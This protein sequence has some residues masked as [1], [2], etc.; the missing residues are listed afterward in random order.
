MLT[1]QAVPSLERASLLAA[2]SGSNA[3]TSPAAVGAAADA[4]RC[5]SGYYLRSIG[6]I[7]RLWEVHFWHKICTP[8][9]TA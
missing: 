7:Q 5:A 8:E 9:L 4:W 2:E 6:R 3:A 1:L